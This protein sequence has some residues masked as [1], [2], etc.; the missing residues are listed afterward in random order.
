MNKNKKTAYFF[1][2]P[3]IKQIYCTILYIY[4]EM[5]GGVRSAPFCL[6]M[7]RF[8]FS[9]KG[10]NKDRIFCDASLKHKC[11]HKIDTF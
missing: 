11:L 8:Q 6:L 9:F 2:K 3:V 7:S 5:G 1:V 4:V 10:C